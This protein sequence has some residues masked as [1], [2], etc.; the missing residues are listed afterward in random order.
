MQYPEHLAAFKNAF[1]HYFFELGS[2]LYPSSSRLHEAC[3]YA[4]SGPG[5]RVRP[6]FIKLFYSCFGG[7]DERWLPAAAAIEMIHTYSL[8]HD[9]LPC[10]DDDEWRR[11]R[12]TTHHAYDEATALL[13]GDALLSDAFGLLATCRFNRPQELALS[14]QE[15]ARNIGGSG[16]VA[17]Q[18]LDMYW[19]KQ[20]GY[21]LEDLNEIHSL[22]TGALIRAA[23]SLG[24]RLAGAPAADIVKAAEI[25]GKIGLAFQIQDDLI[26]IMEGTGKSSGKDLAQGKLT[27][28]QVMKPDQAYALAK[29]LTEAALSDLR[30][31]TNDISKIEEFLRLLLER[32]S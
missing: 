31:L 11:G 15:L 24:A 16:M 32:Q 7:L 22:K 27:Y 9:D 8:V 14:V 30:S 1:D 19:T 29:D 20:S 3:R 5:K 6:L 23:A 12:K 21:T 26:D 4:L 25:G 17:G 10:M 18:S 2:Q 28:L 13:V